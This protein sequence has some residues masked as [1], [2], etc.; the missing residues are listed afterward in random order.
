HNP[1]GKLPVT[2]PY[3]TGQE[4]LYYNR[5]R[6]GRPHDVPGASDKYVS[7]YLDA[8]VEPLFP[9]GHG[10]SY[11]TFR[12]TPMIACGDFSF[13]AAPH[14]E[15]DLICIGEMAMNSSLEVDV[16]VVNTGDRA[17]VEVVQLY[18][19]DEARSVT[20]PVQ[21]L[22]GFERVEL[23]PGE[24]QRVTFTLTPDDLQFW[25]EDGEWTVEPG[26]FTVMVGGSSAETQSARFELVAE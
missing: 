1:G 16:Q 15:I 20:P 26:W 18:V 23:G 3:V 12:Y 2:F 11:T 7:R 22:K 4:P 13:E 8:P 9:F 24:S 14:D 19:R 17:G 6:T 10:L 25:G 21:E 5:K